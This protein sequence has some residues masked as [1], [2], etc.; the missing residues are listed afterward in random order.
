M[1]V[2][3]RALAGSPLALKDNYAVLVDLKPAVAVAPSVPLEHLL[4][5]AINTS[6]VGVECE[7]AHA[8]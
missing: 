8:M 1:C 7:S 3:A 4:H 2:C 6:A 5:V